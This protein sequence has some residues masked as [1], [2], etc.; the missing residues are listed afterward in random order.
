[1]SERSNTAYLD[2]LRGWAAVLVYWHHHELWA[3]SSAINIFE[4]AY[5][6]R[7]HFHTVA[8]PGV[9]LLFNG[10]HYAT[11]TFFIISGYVLAH[12]PLD[13]IEK[14]RTDQLVEHLSSAVFR[15]WIRLYLPLLITTFL[16]M[17]SWHVFDL[18]IRWTQPQA[19]YLA[20]LRTWFSEVMDF[21]FP[22]TRVG[23]PW[24]SYNDHLWSIPVEL[25]GSWLSYT[26]FLAL[27]RSSRPTRLSC[28]AVLIIYFMYVVHD[29]W[30]LSFFAAGMLLR[31]I[32]LWHVS[33]LPS[34]YNPASD[35]T[36][37]RWW[38]FLVVLLSI[39]LGGVPHCANSVCIRNNPGWS[40]LS[41][42][43]PPLD[44]AYDPKWH[45]LLPASAL[46]V[47]AVPH[48]PWVRRAFEAPLSLYLGRISYSLYLV[49]GPV[50]RIAADTIYS[51]VG[52]PQRGA[53]VVHRSLEPIV[54]IISLPS[55]G[56]LGMEVGFLVPQIL[57]LIPVT[58]GLAHMVTW[59][60]DQPSM[61]F[62]RWLYRWSLVVERDRGMGKRE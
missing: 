17:T 55:W 53:G 35:R 45:Y 18:H 46:V 43:T 60:V 44:L 40:A 61:K 16:Y 14:G 22:F 33:R 62:A 54:N 5:G 49:H 28:Q 57:L 29:G 6:Y 10:G 23:S 51:A 12:R 32:E 47:I 50:M 24:L 15:R 59:A 25:K 42:L 27:C 56:P 38:W 26:V 41:I 8:L 52:W 36:T 37:W 4:R 1:M 34:T 30:Y 58:F 39:Y 11:A 20:E 31:E 21:A 7:G 48:I 9:R 2:G 19:C 3:H 13:L